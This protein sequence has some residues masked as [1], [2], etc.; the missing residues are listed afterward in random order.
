MNQKSKD[1]V[2]KLKGK[3]LKEAYE[4]KKEFSSQLLRLVTSGFGLVA[5]LAWNEV[6]K[7]FISRYIEPLFGEASSFFSLFVYALVVTFLAVL[8]TYQL[9]KF[10]FK[11][12]N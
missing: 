4:F 9:S 11:K 7:E 10:I 3:L 1:P 8:V 5:A 2:T 6:I 12:E